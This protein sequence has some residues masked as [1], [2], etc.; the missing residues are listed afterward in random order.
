MK[1]DI[2]T[3]GNP[4]LRAPVQEVTRDTQFVI[5]NETFDLPTLINRMFETI[6]GTGIGLAAPQIGLS[7]ALFVVNVQI[8]E[9]AYFKAVFINPKI[10]D[11]YGTICSMEEGCLSVPGIHQNVNRFGSILLHYY[12]ENFKKHHQFFH[13]IQS[14]VIQHEYDH[15]QGILFTDY[16]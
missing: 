13:D 4:V 15:L 11:K 5:E 14:R 1:L 2:K 10:I 7:Y 3:Y 12:D 9:G 8:L 16:K 6:V